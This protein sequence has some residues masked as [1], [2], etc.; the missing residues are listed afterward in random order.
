[1]FAY[2]GCFGPT[3]V[4]DVRK[5]HCEDFVCSSLN[6]MVG[7]SMRDHNSIEI[8]KE[9]MGNDEELVV[10]TVIFMDTKMSLKH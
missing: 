9:F 6:L 3:M 10:D 5:V 8:A 4:E 1:M 2:A 7:L